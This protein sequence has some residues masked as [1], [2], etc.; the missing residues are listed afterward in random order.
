M[1]SDLVDLVMTLRDAEAVTVTSRVK[2]ALE[3]DVANEAL[4]A[5]SPTDA[6][7]FLDAVATADAMSERIDDAATGGDVARR[8]L[9]DVATIPPLQPV[10]ISCIG[11]GGVRLNFAD[12]VNMAKETFN[13]SRLLGLQFSY[14]R[15]TVEAREV[16][17]GKIETRRKIV[18]SFG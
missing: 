1:N 15:E 11:D 5:L 10:I 3:S 13:L 2:Q 18:M 7:R 4:G 17:G 9:A 14:E 12:I 16:R 6:R 8:F